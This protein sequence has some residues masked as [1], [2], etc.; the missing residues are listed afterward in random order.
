MRS[1]AEFHMPKLRSEQINPKRMKIKI[2]GPKV[3]GTNLKINNSKKT[4]FNKYMD[5][6]HQ[7]NQLKSK[8][9]EKAPFRMNDVFYNFM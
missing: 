4:V 7:Q 8:T 6:I 3:S 2:S 1:F 9:N 5:R